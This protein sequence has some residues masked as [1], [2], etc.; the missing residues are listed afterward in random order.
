MN[1]FDTNILIY[2]YDKNHPERQ[3]TALRLLTSM[4]DGVMLWQVAC[5]FVSASRKLAIF[6]ITPHDAWRYLHQQLQV[7]PLVPPRS[8]VLARARELHLNHQV[9]FWDALVIAACQDADVSCLYSEDLPGCP[10]PG[11]QIINPFR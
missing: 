2:A 3:E 4:P 5:E 6:G 10:V 7:F 8:G 1:A 11:L 9:A